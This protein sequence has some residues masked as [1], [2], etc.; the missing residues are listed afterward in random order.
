MAHPYSTIQHKCHN[1]RCS[2][3]CNLYY[4]RCMKRMKFDSIEEHIF[5]AGMNVVELLTIYLQNMLI[6]NNVKH[7]FHSQSMEWHRLS[8]HRTSPNKPFV[9]FILCA[10]PLRP[11]TVCAQCSCMVYYCRIG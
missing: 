10:A 3:C 8:A 11:A 4:R 9:V 7:T 1:C 6:N 2:I 5:F